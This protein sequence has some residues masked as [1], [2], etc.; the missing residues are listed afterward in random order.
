MCLNLCLN[1]VLIYTCSNDNKNYSIRYILDL[2][3]ITGGG[4]GVPQC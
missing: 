2:L 3:R 1:C 4:G